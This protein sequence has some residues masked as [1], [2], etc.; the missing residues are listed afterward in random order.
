RSSDL[1]KDRFDRIK[2]LPEAD[3]PAF[4]SLLQSASTDPEF[5]QWYEG[6]HGVAMPDTRPDASCFSGGHSLS[7]I[8]R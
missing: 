2:W 7:A 1:A 5:R 8:R 6:V 4:Q 3:I